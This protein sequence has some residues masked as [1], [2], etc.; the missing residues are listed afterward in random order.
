MRRARLLAECS[1]ANLAASEGLVGGENASQRGTTSTREGVL[2]GALTTADKARELLAPFFLDLPVDTTSSLE[3]DNSR[4]GQS[5]QVTCDSGRPA[6]RSPSAAT[7]SSPFRSVY[8][9]LIHF[10][11]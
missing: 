2:R 6:F 1:G 7:S 9:L 8:S 10:G 5:A 4:K 11:N 3:M